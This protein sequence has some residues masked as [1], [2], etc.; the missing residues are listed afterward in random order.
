MVAADAGLIKSGT[1]TLEAG[2]LGCVHSIMYR[3][4]RLTHFIFHYLI[5][6]KG[7]VGLVNLV[8]GWSPGK[9]FLIREV[10]HH[11]QTPE[12]W[13]DELLSLYRDQE[14]RAKISEGL[15]RVRRIVLGENAGQSPSEVAAREIIEWVRSSSAH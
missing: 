7:P 5:R 1:S 8:A 13:S 4:N 12:D 9:P 2:V 6:Y 10:L 11:A 3:S 14:R 15:A